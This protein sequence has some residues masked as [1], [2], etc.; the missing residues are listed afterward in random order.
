MVVTWVMELIAF[1]DGLT[2]GPARGLPYTIS[3]CIFPNFFHTTKT[4][5]QT[6]R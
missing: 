4:A 1:S 6:V 5:L 2:S 3:P